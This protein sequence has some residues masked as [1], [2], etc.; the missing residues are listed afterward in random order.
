M[1]RERDLDLVQ[2]TEKVVP[3]V[4]RITDYGKYLYKEEKKKRTSKQKKIGAL[5]G[6]RLRFNISSHDLETRVKQTEKF[7]NQGNKVKVEMQ[8]RG[9]EKA[10]AL[11]NFAKDKVNTFLE[12][13]GQRLSFKIERELKKE[14]R[15]FTMIISKQ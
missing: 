15:G 3:P 1:A 9:R 10:F 8:L 7:L 12:L 2:V 4:C 14:A 5:K 13:L 11:Q 6:V